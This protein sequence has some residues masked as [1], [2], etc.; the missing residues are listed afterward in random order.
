MG[1]ELPDRHSPRDVRERFWL[2][3]IG[4]L[5][6]HADPL[7]LTPLMEAGKPLALLTYV[8]LAP[9]G[10][11][12]RDHV[13]ELLWPGCGL[14]E[15]RHSLRQ[16]LY[17]L[18]QSTGGAPLVRLRGVD[19]VLERRVALDCLEGERLTA[20]GDLSRGCELLD[21]N[22]L[23]GF[24]VPESHE[25]ED[26]AEAQRTRFRDGWS[27]AA[28]RLTEDLLRRG[29]VTQSLNLA[30]RL[31]TLRPFDNGAI[32]LVMVALAEAGKHATALA[33][34]HAY[35]ELLNREMGEE[36]GAELAA[37]A[38]E[39]EAYLKVRPEPRGAVL[40][41][42]GRA[43]QWA[44]LEAAWEAARSANGST[45]LIEGAAGMGKT[46]VLTELTAR[47]RAAGGV[48]LLGKCF[49]I[50]R[51][52]PYAAVAEALAPLA[53]RA[54]LGTLGRA[55]LSEAARLL[56]ELR[57]RF[58]DLPAA[59]AAGS[60]AAKRRLHEALARC[61][62]AIAA[63]AAVLVAVD[64]VHWGDAA[65]LE[66]LH[67]LSKRLRDTHAL[68][69]ATY[70]P[71]ELS[72]IARRFA[73]SLCTDRLADVVLLEG[74]TEEDIGDLLTTLATFESRDVAE[75]VT[76]LLHRHT[77]GNPLFLYELLDSLA[78]REIFVVRDGQ[79]WLTTGT[80]ATGLPRTLGKLL[81]DRVDALAPWMRACV[82][83]LAVCGEES[84]TEIVAAAL[85]LSEPRAELALSVLEEERLVKRV[86]AGIFD[87]AHDEL[88]RLVYQEIPD[89][90]R[91]LLHA[92][93]GVALE[94]QGESKRPGGP[95]RL[96]HHFDQAADQQ[97][98]HRYALMAAAEAGALAVGD[99]ER[100][101]LA[102][103]EAHAPRALPPRAAGLV[104]RGRRRVVMGVGAVALALVSAV[105]GFLYAP[106]F[107]GAPGYRQGTIYFGEGGASNPSHRLRWASRRGRPAGLELLGSAQSSHPS[108]L[109][110]KAVTAMN[111]THNKVFAVRGTDT[112]QLTFGLSDDVSPLWAPDGSQFMFVRGWR[113][114][115][116]RY[117]QNVF[118]MDSSGR[119]ARQ[120]TD[121]PWQDAVASWSPSGT[122][123]VFDRDSA[124]TSSVTVADADGANL[125]NVSEHFGLPRVLSAAAI[126][127]DG[128]RLAIVYADTGA[129]LGAVYVVDLVEQI[130][131]PLPGT[132]PHMHPVQPLWSPDGEWVAYLTGQGE[133]R[134]LWVIPVDGTAGPVLVA[135]LPASLY[136][137]E[138]RRGSPRWAA[139]VVL[140]PADMS[141]G[142]GRGLR[143]SARV[144]A[145]DGHPV[146][147]VLRWSVGDTSI[148]V[149]DD[150]GFVR[151]KR[152]GTTLL[153]ASTGGV[154][155]DTATVMVAAATQDTLFREDWTHGL[156]TTR[157]TPFGFP[158]S[159]VVNGAPPDG[160][161]AFFNNGDYNHG[162][163]A[164]SVRTFV[165]GAEGLTVETEA[166]LPF[167]GQHWQNWTVALADDP[168]GGG[169][170]VSGGPVQIGV[171]GPEPTTRDPTWVCGDAPLPAPP[172]MRAGH[173][174]H[175]ALV[176]RP[177]GW[178][179]C[180]VDGRLY[181]PRRVPDRLFE[182]PLA[183]VLRG[184]SVG[185]R[186]YHGPVVVTRGLRY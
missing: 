93:V 14:T 169:P 158:R 13:A 106:A 96:A 8:A 127:P 148:A 42:A 90:R 22:F 10:S 4:L 23:E 157:W 97:R 103:A 64:D 88:R 171:S 182:Q 89:E 6:L 41:F 113:A 43:R 28:R 44:A 47:V 167:T 63:R 79:W 119:L 166:W 165:V 15:S 180:W 154:R 159:T 184:H 11:M 67:L 163:G 34:F 174:W 38:R 160:R 112:V 68:V 5:A 101:H 105:I 144:L 117:Q 122:R 52:V 82:E 126:A 69:V 141:L 86:G 51:A 139:R 150:L 50:E 155:A 16:C 94:S 131:R 87:L 18:R 74:L 60:D 129:Q 99:A 175:I 81:A 56:P 100:V 95:A 57:D 70:R 135:E 142:T 177:D 78:R 39:L 162:S 120:L 138:W 185:T 161:P 29:D 168:F 133:S 178:S 147:A 30:E 24:A 75:S 36:P 76:R 61:V 140:Q 40:P 179:E 32:R 77:G 1:A 124:G 104:R 37:Y 3:T 12:P 46:R 48:V 84:A 27:R 58:A 145:P 59:G 80:G 25:F 54:E 125:W 170:E 109:L 66:I 111:E 92:A 151:G 149:V 164:V 19:L 31:A 156:D 35:A 53:S 71:A 134:S 173:W 102:V 107:G 132:P 65:T 183:I 33:R 49:E 72:P 73:R 110:S 123:I 55:W 21:G 83:T 143:A 2:R 130:A 62:E 118:L 152:Q 137:H 115:E 136:P 45:W 20:N 128:H 114:S 9:N 176:V 85:Q 186:I 7:D 26:W 98:A 181:G 121:T 17:R 91:R 108:P 153:I 146:S 116:T 172:P